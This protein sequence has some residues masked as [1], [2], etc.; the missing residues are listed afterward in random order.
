ME[1]ILEAIGYSI[2]EWD[3]PACD[4]DNRTEGPCV[5]EEVECAN[6]SRVVLLRQVF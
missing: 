5:G 1:E 6:C 2:T 3:C 4:F